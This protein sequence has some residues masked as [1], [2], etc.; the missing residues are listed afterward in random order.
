MCGLRC[1][2]ICAESDDAEEARTALCDF[3]QSHVASK[4]PNRNLSQYISLALYMDGPPHFAPRVK[5]DDLP[6]DALLDHGLRG[7]AGE[8]L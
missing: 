5:E 8:V 7:P 4:D 2:E 1:R 6:P 3:Y